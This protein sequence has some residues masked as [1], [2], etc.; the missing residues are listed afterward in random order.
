MNKPSRLIEWIV[1]G[2]LAL[3][4]A[5]IAVAFVRSEAKPKFNFDLP[6]IGQVKDF[7][8]TNQLDQPV[9]LSQLAGKIWVGNVIFTRCPGPC[10]KLTREMAQLQKLLPKDKAVQLVTLTADPEFDTPKVLQTYGKNF[11]ADETNWMF[12]TGPKPVLYRLAIN[13]LLLAVSEKPV[14]EREFDN[15]LFV[16]STK[17]VLVDTHGRIRGIFEGTDPAAKDG[18]VLA[19]QKLLNEE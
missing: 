19:V 4:V 1:W 2:G 14:N 8:L 3:I 10:A 11:G 18:L 9:S 12:L 7:A 17:F 16:H 15:D 5:G 6:V 13:D